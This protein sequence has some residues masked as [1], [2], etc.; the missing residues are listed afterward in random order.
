MLLLFICGLI[1]NDIDDYLFIF[2]VIIEISVV[3]KMSEKLE[4]FLNALNVD[5]FLLDW[6]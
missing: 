3:L 6:F 1:I 4:Q 5:L 2:T